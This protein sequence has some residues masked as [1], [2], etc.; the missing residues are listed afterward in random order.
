MLTYCHN[1]KRE[2][3]TG[4]VE[5]GCNGIKIPSPCDLQQYHNQFVSIS[6]SFIHPAVWWWL[7][8]PPCCRVYVLAG[9]RCFGNT[10][11]I[12]SVKMFKYTT[13]NN[14]IHL[15]IFR[16]LH[17]ISSVQEYLRSEFRG[18][19]DIKAYKICFTKYS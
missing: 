10:W 12:T 19:F 8:L 7:L 3:I 9:M 6:H 1:C 4:L 11:R 18:L 16:Y 2:P 15:H 13:K 14:Y 17:T 5:Y